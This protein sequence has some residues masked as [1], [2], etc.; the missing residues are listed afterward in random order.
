VGAGVARKGKLHDMT[1]AA[2][3]NA[4]AG[5]EKRLNMIGLL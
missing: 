5:R 2:I 1:I 4:I 3:M